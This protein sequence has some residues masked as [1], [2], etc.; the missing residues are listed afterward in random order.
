MTRAGLLVAA[1]GGRDA[2]LEQVVTRHGQA[3]G[4]VGDAVVVGQHQTVLGHYGGRTAAGQPHCGSL[5]PVEPGL[6]DVDAVG[7]LHLGRR[8]VVEGPHA[9]VRQ[10]PAGQGDGGEQ[11]RPY[12]GGGQH[13]LQ[14]NHGSP[15]ESDLVTAS[16]APVRPARQR[17]AQALPRIKS[18]RG[19]A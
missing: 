11:A 17:T 16:I 5:H 13:R 2:F 15:E 4:A 10:G 3:L 8:E 14:A 19:A 1:T 9:L 6:V 12:A 7:R 18:G